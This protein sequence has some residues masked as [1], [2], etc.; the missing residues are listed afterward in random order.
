MRIGLASV[1]TPLAATTIVCSGR[2]NDRTEVVDYPAVRQQREAAG[3]AVELREKTAVIEASIQWAR[4]AR[5]HGFEDLADPAPPVADNY[6]TYPTVVLPADTTVEEVETVVAAC[7]SLNQRAEKAL[8]DG[9]DPAGVRFSVPS[10]GFADDAAEGG[11]VSVE[12]QALIE[13]RNKVL[14]GG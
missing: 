9:A 4:C 10:V 6:E 11:T 12:R 13:A 5:E 14:L 2:A 1:G 3:R 7:Q 8:R